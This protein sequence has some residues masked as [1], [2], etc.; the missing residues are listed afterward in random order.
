MLAAIRASVCADTGR[1]TSAAAPAALDR[2]RAADGV[3]LLSEAKPAPKA[4]E[5]P[6]EAVEAHY[7]CLERL[8]ERLRHELLDDEEREELRDRILRLRRRRQVP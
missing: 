4:D 6:D 1:P 7:A 2:G 5:K 3:R 8:E